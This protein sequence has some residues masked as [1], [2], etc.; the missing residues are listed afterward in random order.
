MVS[1]SFR[2]KVM[3]RY[4]AGTYA[5]RVLR[6]LHFGQWMRFIG[7]DIVRVLMGSLS[8]SS[9]PHAGQAMPFGIGS[10]DISVMKLSYRSLLCCVRVLRG[11]RASL[12]WPM[13]DGASGLHNPGRVAVGRPHT[14]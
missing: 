2:A 5:N 13:S 1:R 10:G 3:H 12:S 8:T 9:S 6:K 7:G 4:L 11:I 14:V